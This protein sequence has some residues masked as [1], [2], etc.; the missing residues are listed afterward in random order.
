LTVFSIFAPPT[1]AAGVQPITTI[2]FGNCSG[3]V[4]E[5]ADEA[6]TDH[7]D[8]LRIDIGRNPDVD[9]PACSAAPPICT[10]KPKTTKEQ[11]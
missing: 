7:D 5:E 9:E 2:G 3:A 8:P 11:G 10:G 6:R 1:I 4:R